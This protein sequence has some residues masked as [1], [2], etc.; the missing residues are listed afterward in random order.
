MQTRSLSLQGL[1]SFLVIYPASL[2]GQDHRTT[3]LAAEHA[4][5][6]LSRDS[7]LAVMLHQ[8]GHRDVVLL[9]PGAPVIRGNAEVGRFLETLPSGDSLRL[10][11]QPLGFELSQDSGL[12]ITWGVAV[13][14]GQLISPGPGFGRFISVRRRDSGEWKIAAVLFFGFPAPESTL[15][16]QFR[17]T[18]PAAKPSGVAGPFIQADLNFAR[19]AGDSGAAVAFRRWAA[20]EA[21]IFG[22]GGLLIR[23]PDAIGHAVAGP[24]RWNWHPVAAGAAQGGDLGW[25]VGE[26]IITP[27]GGQSD[28]SK[29]LTVWRRQPGGAIR[30]INDGGN[31]R[32]PAR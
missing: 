21:V 8:S 25:T 4:A 24:A 27:E 3:L 1:I 7:G 23:G 22:R 5:A 32:P 28:Y 6:E 14:S 13:T 11:W 20:P 10:T 19:M 26:A 17:I 12:G 16:T 2:N 15:P 9:W 31:A 29:Y 30:F 18:Q